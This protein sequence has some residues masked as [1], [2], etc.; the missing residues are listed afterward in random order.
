MIPENP[1]YPALGRARSRQ[2]DCD[3][4][5]VGLLIFTRMKAVIIRSR[6]LL[7]KPKNIHFNPKLSAMKPQKLEASEPKTKDR[8]K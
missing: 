6:T 8:K 5:P 4:L 7:L 2:K 1:A 3:S